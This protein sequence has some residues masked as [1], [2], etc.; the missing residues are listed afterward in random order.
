MNNSTTTN[1]HSVRTVA[2]LIVTFVVAGLAAIHSIIPESIAGTVDT[3]TSILLF[4][5]HYLAGN[6]ASPSEPNTPVN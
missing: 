2:L 3:L 4:L 1:W 6:S 5:E